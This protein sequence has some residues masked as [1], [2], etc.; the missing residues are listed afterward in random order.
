M[1]GGSAGLAQYETPFAD[2]P[3]MKEQSDANISAEDF[4]S[5][6][7][8]EAESP[9]SRTYNPTANNGVTQAGEEFVDLLSELNDQEFQ[10]AIYEMINEVEDTWRNKVTN[11]V[12][13]N[14][15][16]IPYATQQARQYFAPVIK[17]AES[18]ID[19]IGEHFSGNN[20]SDQSEAAIESYFDNLEFDHSQYTPVQEQFLGKIFN[21]VKSVVKK[22]VDLAKKGIAAGWQ[23]PS[24]W[25]H[26]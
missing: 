25:P 1:N 7:F 21:K 10:E 19:K 16:Y 5:N 24:H 22:G 17:E 8:Q 3:V 12:A 13:M 6:Y 26:P 23:D 4:F 2:V 14:G 15:N 11:E 9:F 18:M 20:L